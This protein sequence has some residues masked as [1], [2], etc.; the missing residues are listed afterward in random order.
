MGEHF[1]LSVFETI[2]EEATASALRELY[3]FS[4]EG[5][6]PEEHGLRVTEESIY[7]TFLN[8]TPPGLKE[9]FRNL[10]RRLHG[11]PYAYEDVDFADDH[12]DE[13][14]AAADLIVGEAVTG[15]LDYMFDF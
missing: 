11:G 5:Q 14:A 9:Q 4:R 1:L 13:A 7:H 2:G 12:G 15:T 8:H 3:L 6:R 10:Y